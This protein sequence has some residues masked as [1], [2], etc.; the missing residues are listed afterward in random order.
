[1][2]KHLP[3]R[4]S[5]RLKHYDYSKKDR[6]FITICIKDK[7]KILGK[8]K[9]ERYIELTQIGENVE[10]NIKEIEEIYSNIKI[11]E[12]VIMPNHI[13]MILRIIYKNGISI[14]RIVKHYKT[15][16]TKEIGHSIWQKSFYEHVI[17]DE[18]DYL[19]IK[20]YIQNNIINWKKDKYF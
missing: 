13:H 14:S 1:M 7:M 17:R 5:I 15:N 2:N 19:R 10:K 18:K 12:Y 16:I 3:S 6:Y 4:K 20:E 11:E 9:E 8:I